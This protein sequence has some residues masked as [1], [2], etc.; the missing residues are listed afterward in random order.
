VIAGLTLL[1]VGRGAAKGA[2]AAKPVI[3]AGMRRLDKIRHI[4]RKAKPVVDSTIITS[5]AI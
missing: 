5:G 1:P 2:K 4:W 3:N